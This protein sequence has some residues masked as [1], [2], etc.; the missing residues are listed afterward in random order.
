MPKKG[1]NQTVILQAAIA[2]VEEKGYANFS[3][4]ELAARLDVKPASLYN[5]VTGVEEI[6]SMVAL[7]AADMLHEVLAAA[8]TGK[9]NDTAFIDGSLA[10]LKFAQENPELYEALIR[11]PASD[12]EKIVKASFASYA[13]LREIIRSYG[14]DSIQTL[15]FLRIFRSFMHGYVELTNNGFMQ[16]GPVP[17]D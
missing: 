10:Y 3:L 14:A 15:N 1:L 5:F 7:C 4:R 16:R 9:N 13:P 6:N 2:L 12:D 17:K 8:V 11:M